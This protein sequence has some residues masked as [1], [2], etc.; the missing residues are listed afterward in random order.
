MDWKIS[1]IDEFKIFWSSAGGM[2]CDPD[3]KS[4]YE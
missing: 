1:A 4:K 2:C 3:N